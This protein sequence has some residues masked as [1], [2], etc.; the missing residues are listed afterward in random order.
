MRK[1]TKLAG[2]ALAASMLVSPVYASENRVTFD[3][4]RD[5][6]GFTPIYADYPGGEGVE[7]FYE[8]RHGHEKIPI[9]GA[10]KGLFL[11]GS[12][13][14][15]DLF[16][17]YYKELA[18]FQPGRLYAFHVTF[19]LATNVDGGMIGVGGSPGASVYVKGGIA[20]EEPGRVQDELGYCRLNLDKGNQGQGGTDLALLG[21]LEKEKAVRSEEYEW[22]EFSFDARARADAEG[23]LWLVLGTD[24]GFEAVS[25]YYLDGISL[26]WTEEADEPITRG[27]AIRRMYDDL[28]P[29]GEDAP[30]FTDVGESSPCWAALGWAQKNGLVSGYGGGVFG[31][32]DP[33]TVEQAAVIL[34]RYAG[35]PA[36]EWD[37]GSIEASDWAEEAVAWGIENGLISETDGADGGKPMDEFAF[38]RAWGRV[39]A[40][41]VGVGPVF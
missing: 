32:D 16:M 9:D 7:E 36:V 23:R 20:M 22:K 28:R 19:R 31:P 40:A 39:R 11:S 21:N 35:S 34:Y 2:L 24:S 17:A 4:E 8:L 5:D 1:M 30:D 13:H 37:G 33:L 29:A 6:S 14:S 3:F 15:D 27:G 18:G 12:N 25:S 41:Q 38:A 26:V 10:G